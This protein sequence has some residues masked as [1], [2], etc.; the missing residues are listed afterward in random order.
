MP[1]LHC[2]I[3]DLIPWPGIEPGPPALSVESEPLDHQGSPCM[4][5]LCLPFVLFPYHSL[6][7][8]FTSV[9]QISTNRVI[10]WHRYAWWVG[11]TDSVDTS[12]QTRL[13]M[14]CWVQGWGRKS[15]PIGKK[16]I[17][18]SEK[19]V[20]KPERAEQCNG[21]VCTGSRT[22]L[23]G[24]KFCSSHLL[25]VRPWVGFLIHLYLSFLVYTMGVIMATIS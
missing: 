25:P 5:F 6:D 10:G 19:F 16:G 22:R 20:N 23:P 8:I 15:T 9:P 14:A 13:E 7:C 17:K 24:I 2:G 18:L 12:V 21:W 3:W 1:A 4:C 11:P